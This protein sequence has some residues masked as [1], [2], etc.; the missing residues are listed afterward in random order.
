MFIDASALAAMMTDEEEARRLATKMRGSTVRM[1]SP[2]VV[3][4]AIITVAEALGLSI[5]ETEKAVRAFLQLANIQLLAVPP[6]AGFSA[7]AAYESFGQGRHPANLD[8]DQCMTY[9]CAQYYRQPL[10]CA[11]AAFALTDLDL[12]G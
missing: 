10:L 8:R 3:T 12:V 2:P 7:A 6:R 5:A 1:M 4:A 11:L 9:A